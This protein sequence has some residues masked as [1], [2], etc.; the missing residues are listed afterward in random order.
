MIH[1]SPPCQKFSVLRKANEAKGFQ[2][3]DF[4]AETRERLI[5]QGVPWVMENVPGAPLLPSIF[6]CGSMFDL[7][8]GHMTHRRQ[9]RRHR[10]FESNQKLTQPKCHHEGETI[11]VYGG[12]PMRRTQVNANG[13]RVY[14]AE[15]GGYQ[16]TQIEKEEAMGITWMNRN[17][18]NQAIPP[19]Y[20]RYIGLQVLAYIT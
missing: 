4:I 16:G 5:K 12:G 20:T 6:L 10:L 7:G 1:A 18:I 13:K 8:C 14:L 19:A 11:G 3:E 15:R 2:Y 9:L 17:E